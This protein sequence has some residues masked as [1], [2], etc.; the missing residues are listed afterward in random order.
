MPASVLFVGNS[1]TYRGGGLDHHLKRLLPE[2]RTGRVV[3]GGATLERLLPLAGEEIAEGGW[4]AVVLQD[5]L[6]ETSVEAFLSS[7]AAGADLVRSAGARPYLLE[8]WPY[9]RL[10]WIDADGIEA[11]HCRAAVETGITVIPAGR[12]WLRARER[13]PGL[14]LLDRDREHPSVA[15]SWLAACTVAVVLTNGKETPANFR[16][17]SELLQP[18]TAESL[19]YTALVA[20]AEPK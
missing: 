3:K 13:H 5:D 12:V 18:E 16:I 19:L 2:I 8:T 4:D 17:S 6:P 7:A 20:A 11:A 14:D 10:G 1:L 9:A 15:G